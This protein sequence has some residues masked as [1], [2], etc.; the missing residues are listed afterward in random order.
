[1]NNRDLECVPYVEIS[2][3]QHVFDILAPDDRISVSIHHDLLTISPSEPDFALL[4][5]S[6]DQQRL[7][8]NYQQSQA[9][10]CS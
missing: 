1:M 8:L 7:P 4:L 5:S 9:L 10:V 3:N 6:Q 2:D